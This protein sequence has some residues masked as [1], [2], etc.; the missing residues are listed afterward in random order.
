[1][2]THGLDG[3][4]RVKAHKM[5][6]GAGYGV[7]RSMGGGLSTA[8][9]SKKA[10]RGEVI[11]AVHEH[12]N[13]EHSGKH[14]KLKLKTGGVA[15][16]EKSAHRPDKKPRYNKGGKGPHT[17]VNIMVAPSKSD[18]APA[19]SAPQMPP[20]P[21]MAPGVSPPMMAAGMRPP[22]MK[23]GG[24]MK[25]IAKAQGGKKITGYEAGAGSGEGRLEKEKNYK[26]Y[27]KN[28]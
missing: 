6:R 23:T 22:T 11:K 17:K 9:M 19:M 25:A 14:S 12:E 21:P 26:K 28:Y 18:A 24:A 4:H 7:K 3:E 15:A 1:M 27:V 10:T 5:V 2:F 8:E 13:Q 16:H 20:R